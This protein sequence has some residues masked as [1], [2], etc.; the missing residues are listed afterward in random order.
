MSRANERHYLERELYEL[1]QREPEIFEFLQAGSLD[2]VWYWNLEDPAD[3]W[4]SDRFWEVLGWD[5]SV[6]THK[7]EEWQ[8]LIH[9]DDLEI[10]RSEYAQS[11]A[12][13]GRLYD[14]PA[15]RYRRP[16]G[17]W[18]WVRCRGHV[19]R[20]A[21]GK[22]I[23]M[24]GAHNDITALKHVESALAAQ[25]QAL[26]NANAELEGFARTAS[27]DLKAPLR[28]VRAFGELLGE[29]LGEDISDDA[30]S[31]LGHI[32][33]AVGRM[34]RLVDD[35][36]ELSMTT[37]SEL[38]YKPVDLAA[39]CED[40]V[41]DLRSTITEAGASMDIGPLPTIQGDRVQLTQLM[42]N[43]IGNAVKFR[44]ADQ[45]PHV[46]VTATVAEE[47]CTMTVA[48]NGIGF[49]PKYAERIFAPFER[50]H[51][52]DAYEGSGIGLA[53]CE[54]IVRRH[55]GTITAS[56]GPAAGAEFTVVLPVARPR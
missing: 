40:A 4:L 10:A 34:Q 7:A 47:V 24:L 56:V 43:L 8:A 39:L 54:R 21:A 28:T 1:V 2:G 33:Q 31:Y 25:N 23:R 49:D 15:V 3:E 55:A 6:R 30:R 32:T 53:V 44:R 12:Q 35:L 16:D 48:D 20:D 46:S 5:P 19:I 36:L 14:C 38:Q 13:P 29:T 22:P 50:L 26:I 41:D 45:A 42:R 17:A 18:T 52:T 9:P 51:A 11:I 37:A 27:H